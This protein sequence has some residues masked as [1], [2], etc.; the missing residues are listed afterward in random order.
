MVTD[1]PE[2][3]HLQPDTELQ[4]LQHVLEQTGDAVLV[5]S[6]RDASLIYVNAQAC[7]ALGY[8]RDD[9]LQRSLPDISEFHDAGIWEESVEQHR[10]QGDTL[11]TTHHRRNDGERVPVEVSLRYVSSARGDYIVESARD[12]SQRK[13]TEQRLLAEK[14]F[15][16]ELL[17]GLP[18]IFYLFDADGRMIRWNRRM[19]RVS[20]YSEGE[21]L[22]MRPVDFIAEDDRALIAEKIEEA[23]EKGETTV[24]A[25]LAPKQGPYVP[26]LFTGRRIT[27]A[28]KKCLLGLGIDISERLRI[29]E[30]LRESE[31]RYRGFVENTT[32]GVYSFEPREPI[33]VD[34]PT[35]AQIRRLYA[36]RVVACND[37]MAHMYGY[38]DAAA[39]VGTTL[40]TLHGGPDRPTNLAFL[41]GWIEAGYRATD[42]ESREVDAAG[43]TVWFSNS[44]AGVVEHRRLVRVW[45]SQT[46]ITERKRAEERLR[47]SASVFENTDEGVVI[48]DPQARI[49]DV[50]RAFV[51][52]TGYRREEVLGRDPGLLSSGRHDHY[53]FAT[54]W[55]SL[56]E[57]G[58]WR[59]ELWNRRRDG[60][61]YPQWLTISGVFGDDGELTHYVGV[62]SDISQMKRSEEQLEFLAHHDPLTDLPNRLLLTQRLEH[63]LRRAE[64]RSSLLA[65][66]FLDL[67]HFKHI[68]DS[69]GHP[70]GDRL[71][72]DA[73]RLLAQ[74]VREDDTL[75]RI[76]GDEFVL[77][78]EDVRDPADAAGAAEKLLAVFDRPFTIDGQ[79][80]R[81]TVSAGISVYPRDGTDPDT[82]LRNA[83]AA[84]YRAKEE[85]RQRYHFYTE[86]LTRKAFER[87]LLGN[88]LRVALERGQLS[89]VYQPQIDLS[90]G[91]MTGVETLLRWRHPELG[92]I[93]PGR[94]IPLAEETGLIHSIGEWVLRTACAQGRAWLD[95][96]IDVGRIAVN[97]AGP[98]IQRGQLASVVKAALQETGLPASRLELEVTEGFIMQEADDAIRQLDELQRLGVGLAI[99]DFGTGYSSLSYLKRLPIEKLKIDQSFIR[100]IPDDPND[101]AI[102]AAIIA[103]GRSLGLRVIAEGVETPEQAAFVQR[104]GC[105]EAQGYLY[106]RPVAA[107][108]LN[109][110]DTG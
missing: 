92:A 35:D 100:D 34:L 40:A 6:V 20:G 11:F 17:N 91:R 27:L 37:A 2:R 81:I 26:H 82:L 43:S 66:V 102:A 69:M 50:N 9:L 41:A 80:L 51:E 64:R 21:I 57:T 67:D 59:G 88:S 29:E 19:E 47:L 28:G 63:A 53:F 93:S 32:E 65:V 42:V 90:S 54:M 101:M 48:T 24:E 94:F 3:G 13:R 72:Q 76:G 16:S 56:R 97:I 36:G 108:E 77:L 30:A 98:Q 4:V 1:N 79:E 38:R 46:D 99:D 103:L 68:N 14:K 44:V 106:G 55:R 7:R 89:A 49:V 73:A 31:A 85:G 105:Q 96:G 15:T 39:L 33:P 78:L 74:A 62:F 22:R 83:D 70:Q 18:G 95:R 75:A 87:I 71:L 60:A 10:G 8:T 12:V 61:V 107:E 45:G 23:L 5:A 52:I 109:V 25:R 110:E 84:M 58:H 104:E 86:E